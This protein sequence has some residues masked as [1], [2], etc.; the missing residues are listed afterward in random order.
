M[1][2]T[3]DGLTHHHRLKAPLKGRIPLKCL[4]LFVEGGGTDALHSPGPEAG[5][6]NFGGID[7]PSASSSADQGVN[8]IAPR[9]HSALRISSM[10]FFED[11]QFTAV[12][13]CR[14]TGRYPRVRTRLSSR[15][16]GSQPTVDPLSHL[17]RM[18]GFA[19]RQARDQHGGCFLVP[20]DPGS[21]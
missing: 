5:L 1:V 19:D 20:P 6:K 14:H 15:M 21:E 18:C 7:G 13:W 2:S 9:S 12:F 3:T 11:S 8:L 10:I 4:P 16:S 17:R